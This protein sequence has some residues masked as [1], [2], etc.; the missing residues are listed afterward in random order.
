MED[1]EEGSTNSE[2]DFPRFDVAFSFLVPGYFFLLG[3][4]SD[5]APNPP[6]RGKGKA[7]PVFPASVYKAVQKT[8]CALLRS[9]AFCSGLKG[10]VVFLPFRSAPRPRLLPPC[11][12]RKPRRARRV[13]VLAEVIF[14]SLLF[15]FRVQRGM[16]CH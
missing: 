13:V 7:A 8:V 11:K 6:Q 15:A 4:A 9:A 1:H 16:T 2:P 5:F 10:L 3:D 14:T 12:G